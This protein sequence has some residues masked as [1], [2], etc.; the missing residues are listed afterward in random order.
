MFALLVVL[1]KFFCCCILVLLSGLLLPW[2]PFVYN[3]SSP[4]PQEVPCVQ[5]G[6]IWVTLWRTQFPGGRWVNSPSAARSVRVGGPPYDF[7]TQMLVESTPPHSVEMRGRVPARTYTLALGNLCRRKNDQCYI[8]Y[9]GKHTHAH[10]QWWV[11]TAHPKLVPPPHSRGF[12]ISFLGFL[13]VKRGASP[14]G[15]SL[16]QRHH[17][18]ATMSSFW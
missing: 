2:A 9:A 10:T 6:G 5:C 12:F 4:K 17:P 7:K 14:R 1:F 3:E 15:R 16:F 8:L 18:A 13:R 11:Q